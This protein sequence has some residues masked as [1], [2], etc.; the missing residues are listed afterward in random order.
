MN[1]ELFNLTCISLTLFEYATFNTKPPNFLFIPSL[2]LHIVSQKIY[3]W[4]II[5]SSI[6]EFLTYFLN[7]YKDY[8]MFVP[9][10][11]EY[12][13]GTIL[14]IIVVTGVLVAKIKYGKNI[15]THIQNVIQKLQNLG[16]FW[17][18]LDKTSQSI[19]FFD[20]FFI[21]VC[22]NI[23]SCFKLFEIQKLM[24]KK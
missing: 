5:L 9:L 17:F 10:L 13:V 7:Y 19:S 12:I 21:R 20:T 1:M 22:I 11:D 14:N 6:I 18:L 24:I 2:S 23:F 16:L 8:M 15:P 3:I 4:I